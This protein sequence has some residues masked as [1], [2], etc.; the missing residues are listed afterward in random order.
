MRS[1]YEKGFDVV[2][3]T[4]CVAATSQ[5]EHENAIQYDYPMFSRPMT[6]EEFTGTLQGT[7]AAGDTSRSY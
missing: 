6:S 3:L 4:D 1:A 5:A 7:E 2:T